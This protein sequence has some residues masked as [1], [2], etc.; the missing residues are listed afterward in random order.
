MTAEFNFHWLIE[1]KRDFP[2]LKQKIL[3]FLDNCSR[4]KSIEL[5]NVTQKL[6]MKNTKRILKV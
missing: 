3:L 2:L 1:M 4:D 6:T 5:S